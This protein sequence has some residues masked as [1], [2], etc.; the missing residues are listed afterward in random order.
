MIKY[1]N[2]G[3][4]DDYQTTEVTWKNI[5]IYNYLFVTETGLCDAT[6]LIWKN[7]FFKPW[8]NVCMRLIQVYAKHEN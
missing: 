6:L 2:I 7:L 4:V 5:A 1:C 8:L 3:V